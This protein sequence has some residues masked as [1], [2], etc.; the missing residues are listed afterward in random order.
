MLKNLYLYL[1]GHQIAQ[2]DHSSLMLHPKVNTTTRIVAVGD[3]ITEGY[4][5]SDNKKMAWP[6]Q[7]MDMLWDNDKYEVINLGLG[8]RTM[9]KKG[10]LPYWNE[11]FYQKALTSEADVVV[12]M[13]GTNDSKFY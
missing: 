7:L 11:P 3:S 10:D 8:G 12:L 5:S 1:T 6:A 4:C 13:L 2:T 9:M